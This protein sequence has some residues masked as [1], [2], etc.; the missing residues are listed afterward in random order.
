[1]SLQKLSLKGCT[2]QPWWMPLL[3]PD[4]CQQLQLHHLDDCLAAFAIFKE[5]TR[6]F[7]IETILL[8]CY[9]AIPSRHPDLVK[10]LVKMPYIQ[11]FTFSYNDP[12]EARIR[13]SGVVLSSE[14]LRLLTSITAP[15]G[16]LNTFFG[17]YDRPVRY[18]A[19]TFDRANPISGGLPFTQLYTTFPLLETLSIHGL[20]NFWESQDL[21]GTPFSLFSK[22]KVLHLIPQVISLGNIIPICHRLTLYSLP[23]SLT[24]LHVSNS[25]VYAEVPRVATNMTAFATSEIDKLK[26]KLPYL[27]HLLVLSPSQSVE[28]QNEPC[29]LSCYTRTTQEWFDDIK[30]I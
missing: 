20:E 17:N 15:A 10:M 16:L 4:T 25:I 14:V 2:S 21:W 26:A 27:K 3:R 5:D 13:R 30:L 1:M 22:L 19:T 11:S 6:I 8:H 23:I 28:W 18:L 7:A 12:R 29:S 9:S 24:E